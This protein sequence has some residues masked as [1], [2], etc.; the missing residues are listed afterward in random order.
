ME[1]LNEVEGQLTESVCGRNQNQKTGFHFI[2]GLV[3]QRAQRRSLE[4][5]NDKH[6]NMPGH[7]RWM[8]SLK[9]ALQVLLGSLRFSDQLEVITGTPPSRLEVATSV[10]PERHGPQCCEDGGQSQWVGVRQ[11]VNTHTSH[12]LSV[13]Q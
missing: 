11:S 10:E 12:S 13:C 9:E 4:I 5:K 1:S 6:V 8:Q 2:Q 7:I 3:T